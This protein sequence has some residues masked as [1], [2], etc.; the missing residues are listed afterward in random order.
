MPQEKTK[1]GH[2]ILFL[3]HQ[4]ERLK[5]IRAAFTQAGTGARLECVASPAEAFAVINRETVDAVFFNRLESNMEGFEFL[6]R[7][8]E[9]DDVRSMAVIMLT[10]EGDEHGALRA[11][12]D[13]VSDCNGCDSEAVSAYPFAAERAIARCEAARE[14]SERSRAILRSQ[15]QWMFILDAMADYIF[16]IDDRHRLL[17]VNNALA[18]AFH[19]HPRDMVN[20]QCG[21]FFWTRPPE[22]RAAERYPRGRQAAHL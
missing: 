13:G 20:R 19:L 8:R 16:V 6:R 21:D 18:S 17:K 7:L 5:A 12:R 2:K 10:A 15:K 9:E 3:E 14:S 22:R 1:Q 11:L 4:P